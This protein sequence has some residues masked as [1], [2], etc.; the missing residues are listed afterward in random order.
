MTTRR[1]VVVNGR[2]PE[3]YVIFYLETYRGKVWLTSFDSPFTSEA[4]FEPVQADNFVSLINQAA[5]EARG[6]RP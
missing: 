3:G 6:Y 5:K 1:K 2:G 4:I